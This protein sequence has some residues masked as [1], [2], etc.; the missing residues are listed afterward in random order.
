[1]LPDSLNR[2][3]TDY[4]IEERLAY[5]EAEMRVSDERHRRVEAALEKLSTTLEHRADQDETLVREMTNTI[6]RATT[7][8]T[9]LTDVVSELK[10]AVSLNA[11]EVVKI[12]NKL[13]KLDGS[14]GTLIALITGGGAII[15]FLFTLVT[16][17]WDKIFK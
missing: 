15:G 2:R 3:S 13:F 8:I 1:M 7:S 4:S 12:N 17:F 10:Q 14:R 6:I 9:H 16:F 5:L 11:G